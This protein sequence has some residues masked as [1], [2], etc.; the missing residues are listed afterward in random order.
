LARRGSLNLSF[1]SPLPLLIPS[2]STR[3]KEVCG[4]VV[5][6]LYVGVE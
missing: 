3:G 5:D 4:T 6:S 1:P 2:I